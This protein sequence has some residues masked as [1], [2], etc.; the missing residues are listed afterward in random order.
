MW[1]N[2][3]CSSYKRYFQSLSNLLKTSHSAWCPF[4]IPRVSYRP[5]CSF[6][7]FVTAA[8]KNCQ[9]IFLANKSSLLSSHPR[10]PVFLSTW[11]LAP[12][13]FW[14]APSKDNSLCCL[15]V[16][17]SCWLAVIELA[18]ACILYVCSQLAYCDC[19]LCVYRHL[20]LLFH[21]WCVFVLD[22]CT[23]ILPSMSVFDAPDVI[24]YDMSAFTWESSLTLSCGRSH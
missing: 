22:V 21:L 5:F 16:Q 17:P 1:V 23:I 19:M 13:S 12:F 3:V 15:A 8:N 7:L 24:L 18:M 4:C 14:Y 20:L 6:F 9:T 2:F 10:S 11:F